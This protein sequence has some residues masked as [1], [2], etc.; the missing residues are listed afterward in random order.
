MSATVAAPAVDTSR[1]V[2]TAAMPNT[3][4]LDAVGSLVAHSSSPQNDNKHHSYSVHVRDVYQHHGSGSDSSS[5]DSSDSDSSSSSSDT[6]SASGFDSDSDS[7][8]QDT[9]LQPNKPAL[10]T[11]RLSSPRIRAISTTSSEGSGDERGGTG[12]AA[13]GGIVAS[14]VSSVSPMGHTVSPIGS[15]LSF[16]YPSEAA[17]A[18]AA[19]HLNGD[20]SGSDQGESFATATAVAAAVRPGTRQRFIVALLARLCATQDASPRLFIVT[21]LQL[22]HAGLLD[23]VDFLASMP[24]GQE[25]AAAAGVVLHGGRGRARGQAAAGGGADT[26]AAAGASTDNA[27]QPPRLATALVRHPSVDSDPWAGA[28]RLPRAPGRAA[29]SSRGGALTMMRA[30]AA[31]KPGSARQRGGAGGGSPIAGGAGA[32]AGA[33]VGT[34]AGA[35]PVAAA[36]DMGLPPAYARTL[37]QVT[38]GLFQAQGGDT[39]SEWLNS[40]PMPGLGGSTTTTAAAAAIAAAAGAL[41]PFAGGMA[42]PQLSSRYHREFKELGELGSGGFGK[43]FRV[44]HRIDEALYAV[45]SSLVAAGC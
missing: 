4:P 29:A 35:A 45:R 18:A 17:A 27:L 37:A 9:G 36:A 12:S 16:S 7:S 31:G 22:F 19:T 39:A 6:A 11:L 26:G 10:A 2:S 21:C 34:G 15:P 33:G 25:A 28:L 13:A 3:S 14:P 44:Q 8:D 23:N 40:L 41:G 1:S 38:A 32:G 5:D 43:V 20:D 30:A 42:S 24:G